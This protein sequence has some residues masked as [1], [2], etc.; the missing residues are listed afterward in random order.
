MHTP[1]LIYLFCS[2]RFVLTSYLYSCVL[3]SVSLASLIA[4]TE[5][6]LA[7]STLARDI[8]VDDS[9]RPHYP[10]NAASS[11]DRSRRSL[12]PSPSSPTVQ[13][14][15]RA[16]SP[17]P[18]R[19]PTSSVPLFSPS[20]E[21]D[22]STASL[23]RSYTTQTTG[24]TGRRSFDTSSATAGDE[25]RAA[26]VDITVEYDEDDPTS[27][28]RVDI[29]THSPLP[30]ERGRAASPSLRVSISPS[31]PPAPSLPSA[32]IS[33]SFSHINK[34][35]LNNGFAPVP[36]PSPSSASYATSASPSPATLLTLLSTFADV[37]HEY[38]KRGQLIHELMTRERGEEERLLLDRQQQRVDALLAER[39]TQQLEREKAREEHKRRLRDKQHDLDALKAKCAQLQHSLQQKETVVQNLQAEIADASRARRT[40]TTTDGQQRSPTAMFRRLH[41]RPPTDGSEADAAMMRVIRMYEERG[42]EQR[43]EIEFLRRETAEA[44]AI[45]Q[46][47]REEER[48]EEERTE[49]DK[50]SRVDELRALRSEKRQR[51]AEQTQQEERLQARAREAESTAKERAD[52]AEKLEKENRRLLAELDQRVD[53]QQHRAVVLQLKAMEERVKEQQRQ[54]QA[55]QQLKGR[56]TAITP[57]N[58][59]TIL[60]QLATTFGLTDAREVPSLIEQL[61]AVVSA[62]PGLQ[63][64]VR[65]VCDVVLNGRHTGNPTLFPANPT[66]ADTR[67]VMDM[68]LP[69]LRA[70]SAELSQ[71]SSLTDLHA[72][73]LGELSRRTHRF[74]NG[75]DGSTPIELL[76][77]ELADLV[78]SENRLYTLM[79]GPV[80]A[81]QAEHNAHTIPDYSA[82]GGVSS[83]A[84][85]LAHFQHLFDCPSVNGIY[86]KMNELY[87]FANEQRVAMQQMRRMLG[88]GVGVPTA[89]IVKLL[90]ERLGEGGGEDTRRLM[91]GEE[92]RRQRLEDSERREAE[93]RSLDDKTTGAWHSADER[94]RRRADIEAEQKQGLRLTDAER[95]ELLLIELAE[96]LGAASH[97]EL[98]PIVERLLAKHSELSAKEVDWNERQEESSKAAEYGRLIKRL[99]HSLGVASSSQLLDAVNQLKTAP[100]ASPTH[101]PIRIHGTVRTGGSRSEGT[102]SSD[103]ST[104]LQQA[105]LLLDVSSGGLVLPALKKVLSRLSMYEDVM[106]SVDRLVTSLYSMLGVDEIRHILPAVRRLKA[107]LE[108]GEDRGGR[109]GGGGKEERV[110]DDVEVR[111][112]AG[113]TETNVRIS[114]P[115]RRRRRDEDRGDEKHDDEESDTEY[116]REEEEDEDVAATEHSD[117]PS[118]GSTHE[119]TE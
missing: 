40:A 49:Q 37:L 115:V 10:S 68:V 25:Q 98:L 13:V 9:T 108:R 39:V 15:I 7:S 19:P 92:E 74:H 116:E 62:M 59:I 101:P 4:D 61:L 96:L 79:Y 1:C 55:Y 93:L 53:E 24:R 20:S 5:R 105:A 23:P 71:L 65:Q 72:R 21:F 42:D 45:L 82:I 16:H 63:R 86:P 114:S 111:I 102:E 22:Q 103:G 18:N 87:V 95:N 106:P 113:G 77:T 66:A 90:R 3:S 104:A 36:V 109:S 80:P 81:L 41:G 50:G 60:Q 28:P 6:L 17:T 26:D 58:A 83:P 69:T 70:W 44:N 29:R 67:T 54:L 34:L 57:E 94:E 119:H 112:E 48:Q 14:H 56:L 12:S 38:A 97:A 84:K 31:H 91:A 88:L 52:R 107:Q 2:D 27:R 35:L 30:D 118:S 11:P 89:A 75:L 8:D 46:R 99:K 43:A 78:S 100:P 64:F 33:A 47:R 32:S 110:E 117:R 76:F 73:L 85:M 51:E